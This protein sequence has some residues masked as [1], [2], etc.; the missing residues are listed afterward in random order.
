MAR[1]R[2]RQAALDVA[3]PVAGAALSAAIR[4]GLAGTRLTVEGDGPLV[5]AMAAGPVLLVFWH[6]C[7]PMGA[8]VAGR[9]PHRVTN[10]RDPS[11]AGVLGAEVQRRMGLH[12]VA[13]KTGRGAGPAR[14]VL[15]RLAAGD[16]VALAGDGP[17][18]PARALKPAPVDWARVSGARVWTFAAATTRM[19]R[20]PSWDRM[21]FPLPGGRGL[22]SF[23]EWPTALPRRMDDAAREAARS[24]LEAAITDHMDHVTERL[25]RA[26]R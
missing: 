23:R 9:L 13:A 25:E 3:T 2:I 21:A 20:A 6:E 1:S 10:L 7:L 17:S 5:E 11:P 22:A 14:E 19:A 15:R 12:P 8:H 4:A 16:A 26:P 24:A 18:G